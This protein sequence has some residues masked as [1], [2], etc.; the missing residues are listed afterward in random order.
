LLWRL[1]VAPDNILTHEERAKHF[2]EA[3]TRLREA[4]SELEHLRLKGLSIRDVCGMVKDVFDKR[5][6]EDMVTAW[7][8][9]RTVTPDAFKSW[10]DLSI[11]GLDAFVA[12]IREQARI[13][14]EA[15]KEMDRMRGF[16]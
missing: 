2:L 9:K 5:K 16:K 14:N 10:P 4:I 1:T 8:S 12:A 3:D 13:A 11:A 6:A 7:D 15:E